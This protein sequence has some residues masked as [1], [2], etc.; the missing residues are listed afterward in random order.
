MISGELEKIIII[1]TEKKNH[2]LTKTKNKSNEINIT[3]S[4]P[5]RPPATTRQ[6]PLITPT[7]P[8]SNTHQQL[9]PNSQDL[10]HSKVK[11]NMNLL[12]T[13]IIMSLVSFYTIQA[14]HHVETNHPDRQSQDP[15]TLRS[16]DCLKI[17]SKASGWNLILYNHDKYSIHSVP[18]SP[19]CRY[20]DDVTREQVPV[21]VSVYVPSIKD[22][23]GFGFKA[24]AYEIETTCTVWFLGSESKYI[25]K[26]TKVPINE[27]DNK[28][29][30]SICKENVCNSPLSHLVLGSTASIPDEETYICK[31]TGTQVMTSRILEISK[32]RIQFDS[33]G[34]IVS[35]RTDTI[36]NVLDSNLCIMSASSN[37]LIYPHF[38]YDPC[39][40]ELKIVAPGVLSWSKYNREYN[41]HS[42]ITLPDQKMTFWFEHSYLESP[43]L[44][45]KDG[46]DIKLSSDGYLISISSYSPA[47]HKDSES[48]REYVIKEMKV[49]AP[50]EILPKEVVSRYR[51]QSNNLTNS[52]LTDNNSTKIHR[53]PSVEPHMDNPNSS[54][55][56]PLFPQLETTSEFPEP[57]S[58]L[59]RS[60]PTKI[61]L[62]HLQHSY[63]RVQLQYGLLKLRSEI[64]N[65]AKDIHFEICKLKHQQW[66][67]ALSSLFVNPDLMAHYMFP[68]EKVKA[69]VVNNALHIVWGETISNICLPTQF[70]F[71]GVNLDVI[72][73]NKKMWL[74]ATTGEIFSEI[75]SYA[76]S[77]KMDSFTVPLKPQGYYDIITKRYSSGFG[78]YIMESEKEEEDLLFEGEE[79]YGVYDFIP[80]SSDSLQNEKKEL[81]LI[82]NSVKRG[83]DVSK[84]FSRYVKE[85]LMSIWSSLSSPFQIG[86]SW[87]CI[88]AI[89]IFIMYSISNIIIPILKMMGKFKRKDK[90]IAL[91]QRYEHNQLN[92][93][94]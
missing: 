17:P 83:T 25:S 41:K 27:E 68:L 34:N 4:K 23:T 63:S 76:D 71:T 57:R 19:S 33:S 40:L 43:A 94:V 78:N 48:E 69:K 18:S 50:W 22:M 9:T 29:L 51:R 1:I 85:P 56:P 61:S 6:S 21:A 79:M 88:I 5:Q 62:E 91:K 24:A 15:G 30:S 87:I 53:S 10:T 8:P 54:L 84:S 92:P 31:W 13:F 2:N 39:N 55:S 72:V 82:S 49:V 86:A 16:E 3:K 46:D 44:C 80:W 20:P 12:Y 11:R 42:T 70:F 37:A 47:T 65:L 35:P 64:N 36:C 77:Y 45:K 75:P 26:K 58:P 89:I 81:E 73:N 74:K 67:F 60:P 93:I 28:I 7:T 59:R 52:H 32:I 14:H 66:E 90:I 38:K